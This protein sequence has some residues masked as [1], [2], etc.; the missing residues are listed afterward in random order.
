[1]NKIKAYLVV[2]RF[3]E[4]VDWIRNYTDNYIIYN[5]GDDD[6]YD[7][8]QIKRPNIGGNQYDICQFI[9]ENYENLP[10]L[11]AFCQG[12][13]FDHCPQKDFNRLIYNGYYT[14]LFS[15]HCGVNF[16]NGIF[17]E[18]DD[19]LLCTRLKDV[20][21]NTSECKVSSFDEFANSIFENYLS[22]RIL[23]F[24]PGSQF[25]V[26]KERCLYYSRSFWKNLME[27]VNTDIG[28]NG[29]REAHILE[30]AMQLIFETRFKEK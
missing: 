27:F 18:I 5:K 15:T 2:S 28:V 9:Y 20:C 26:E 23:S 25:I 24:P 14:N 1:M 12:N 29:G 10:D 7:F 4:N 6:L 21:P 19:G 3:K 8:K 17:T 11:I 16:P 13:P 22:V 30:R